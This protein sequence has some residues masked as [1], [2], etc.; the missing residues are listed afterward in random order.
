MKLSKIH[1]T[2]MDLL[3]EAFLLY[4]KKAVLLY[5]RGYD[6]YFILKLVID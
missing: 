4:E 6:F 3:D 1:Q 5:D 2:Q